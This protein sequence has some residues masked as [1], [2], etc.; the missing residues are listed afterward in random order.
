LQWH[1]EAV[2][3]MSSTDR[4]LKPEIR[5]LVECCLIFGKVLG[6]SR[7]GNDFALEMHGRRRF[8]G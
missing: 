5:D 4:D 2:G 6:L 7:I 8:T 1:S 3:C